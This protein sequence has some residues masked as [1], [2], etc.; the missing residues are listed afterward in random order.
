MVFAM[1]SL[2]IVRRHIPRRDVL[3]GRIPIGTVAPRQ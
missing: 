3:L 1:I 2:L